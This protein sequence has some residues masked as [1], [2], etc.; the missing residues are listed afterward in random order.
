MMLQQNQGEENYNNNVKNTTFSWLIA[1]CW[2]KQYY[3]TMND[4]KNTTINLGN[5]I[6]INLKIE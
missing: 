2:N 4:P 3:D 5:P 1:L 6:T